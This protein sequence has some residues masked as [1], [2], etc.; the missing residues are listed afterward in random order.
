MDYILSLFSS[1]LLWFSFWDETSL[2]YLTIN[3]IL[4]HSGI[5]MIYME[6][7][8]QE[9]IF[10]FIV[11]IYLILL[12]IITDILLLSFWK[13]HKF[14][15]L[16]YPLFFLIFFR[17]IPFVGVIWSYLI[18]ASKSYKITSHTYLYIIL[19]NIIFWLFSTAV[20]YFSI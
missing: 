2:L 3:W 11:F 13:S 1:T 17:Y 5:S 14:L 4:Q 12:W 6:I 19:A 15:N 16:K 10:K 20:I 9:N 8:Q 7:F 18:W